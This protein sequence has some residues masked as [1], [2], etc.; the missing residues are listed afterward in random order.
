MTGDA[1][2]AVNAD[3]G[4]KKP[5]AT[6][7]D[8]IQKNSAG[9]RVTNEA[10]NE[11]ANIYKAASNSS[12]EIVQTTDGV[13]S[14][15]KSAVYNDNEKTLEAVETVKG[16]ESGSG[17]RE[18]AVG[19]PDG[20]KKAANKT[21]LNNSKSIEIKGCG[22]QEINGEYV[23]V[24]GGVACTFRK[25]QNNISQGEQPPTEIK[26]DVSGCWSIKSGHTVFYT[27]RD[28]LNNIWVMGRFGVPSLP[29][30]SVVGKQVTNI[31]NEGAHS[32]TAT[33]AALCPNTEK[34]TTGLV[35][36]GL[37]SEKQ[38]AGSEQVTDQ[39]KRAVASTFNSISLNSNKKRPKVS[40][41]G[42]H[43]VI[44][45]GCGNPNVNGEY[46]AWGLKNKAPSFRKIGE[47]QGREEYYTITRVRGSCWAIKA[48]SALLYK[49]G[50]TEPNYILDTEW[51]V[52][53]HGVHPAPH[54][55]SLSELKFDSADS[56]KRISA[57]SDNGPAVAGKATK[58]A[59]RTASRFWRFAEEVESET[60]DDGFFDFLPSKRR[61]IK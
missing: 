7:E 40:I 41:A 22:I 43:A 24:A 55:L 60:D 45:K 35:Y 17:I 33:N 38:T 18:N 52:Q 6:S 4:E 31:G 23:S 36:K 3:D 48:D 11:N 8:G 51:T 10:T 58:R 25:V 30:L 26:L 44:I 2:V 20:A 29:Q 15:P 27:S 19:F 59:R 46:K 1:L 50:P 14:V 32:P 57:F 56:K 37:D 16:T 54:P 34:T 21:N 39:N 42:A 9:T 28:P 13:A 12:N 53:K 5:A 47:F 49:T 61:M